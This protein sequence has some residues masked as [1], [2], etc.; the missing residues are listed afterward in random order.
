MNSGSLGAF[1][2]IEAVSNDDIDLFDVI[3]TLRRHLI[4]L[5]AVNVSWDSGLFVPSDDERRHGWT[6]DQ[7]RAVSPVIDD[8]VIDA[9]PGCDGSFEE[10]YFF[11]TLP[12]NLK[13]SAYCNWTG[14]SIGDWPSLLDVRGG[15]DLKAQLEV[16]QPAVVLGAG[17]MLFAISRNVELIDDIRKLLQET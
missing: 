13:L 9:W 3:C 6:I 12:R 15:F 11:S 10:W 17:Q 4:D 2:W 5:R 16:A 1:R 7:G 8:R 14:R